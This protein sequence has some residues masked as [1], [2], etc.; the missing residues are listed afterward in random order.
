[1]EDPPCGAELVPSS[2]GSVSSPCRALSGLQLL[3][4][5]S[6]PQIYRN[7]VPENKYPIKGS[8]YIHSKN[9]CA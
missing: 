8:G 3:R 9:F 1:M 5:I 6:P 7:Q 2:G 4:Y